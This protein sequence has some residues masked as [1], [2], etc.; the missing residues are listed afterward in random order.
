MTEFGKSGFSDGAIVRELDESEYSII[1]QLTLREGWLPGAN[2]VLIPMAIDKNGMFC[3]EFNN[4]I[5]S[6]VCGLRLNEELGFIGVYIC[7]PEY[8][9]KGFGL[10]LFLHSMDY[11][12]PTRNIVLDAVE[13]QVANYSKLGF[14]GDYNTWRFISK[15]PIMTGP[16]LGVRNFMK[17]DFDSVCILDAKMIGF[18]RITFINALANYPNSVFGVDKGDLNGELNGYVVARPALPL[19]GGENLIRVG[20]LIAKDMKT[21]LR[22][23][24]WVVNQFAGN[25]QFVVDALEINM[26]F[27]ESLLAA[28]FSKLFS[29]VRMWTKGRPSSFCVENIFAVSCWE[30]QVA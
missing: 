15:N 24:T 12:G 11:L 13:E 3:C 1:S 20:P 10:Q 29:C 18:S 2:D 14:I 19:E 5:V 23:L 16:H 26:E 17:S 28:G 27:T 30:F 21:A 22:L 7:R 9:G 8:R 4:V 25:I 6:V